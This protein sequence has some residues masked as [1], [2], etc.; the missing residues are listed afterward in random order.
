MTDDDTV[1]EIAAPYIAKAKDADSLVTVVRAH[2]F[3]WKV[4]ADGNAISQNYKPEKRPL[5]Q[6][7]PLR[8][9]AC[10]ALPLSTS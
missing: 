5:R 3:L 2:R 9:Y 4:D 6:E 10:A 8:L 7:S 1:M